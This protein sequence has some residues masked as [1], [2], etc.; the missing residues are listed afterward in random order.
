MWWKRLRL[1]RRS[2]YAYFKAF[3]ITITTGQPSIQTVSV[4]L[5]HSLT[6]YY[7]AF[8]KRSILNTD[9]V[10]GDVAKTGYKS[11]LRCCFQ[12]ENLCPGPVTQLAQILS[13]SGERPKES[14]KTPDYVVDLQN[15]RNRNVRWLFIVILKWKIR[16]KVFLLQ[17]RYSTQP[18]IYIKT[19][20]ET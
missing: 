13:S 9:F 19:Q 3:G 11:S 7:K 15:K 16:L 4:F 20:H 8:D 1:S 12:L 6:Y 17:L 10:N 18:I 2:L 5:N 14:V